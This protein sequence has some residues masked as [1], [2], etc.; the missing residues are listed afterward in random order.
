MPWRL[1]PAGL[2]TVL[3]VAAQTIA[4]EPERERWQRVDEIIKAAR[5]GSGSERAMA[6]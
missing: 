4:H 2:L 5:I 6:F 3:A 1:V